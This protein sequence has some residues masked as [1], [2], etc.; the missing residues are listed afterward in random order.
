M[1]NTTVL[2]AN[3]AQ[4]TSGK[5]K[6]NFLGSSYSGVDLKVL[7]HIYVSN[8]KT[9][10]ILQQEVESYQKAAQYVQVVANSFK[11]VSTSRAVNQTITHF[12]EQLM[13]IPSASIREQ[14]RIDT[15]FIRTLPLGYSSLPQPEI[16]AARN[17][18]GRLE[19][20]AKQ[21]DRYAQ[22]KNLYKESAPSDGGLNV[23]LADLQTISVSSY[24]EKE[25]VRALGSSH[26]KGYTR[27][28]RT[29][30]G[31]MIFTIFEQHP[32]RRL[33]STMTSYGLIQEPL[34]NTELN[35]LLPDQL[36]PIDITAVF[37]NEYGSI[38]KFSLLGVEF[39]N[40]GATYSIE[41][42]LSENVVQ[43]VARDIE[44]LTS[45]GMVSLTSK[46]SAQEQISTMPA[47]RLL[48]NNQEYQAY[49]ERLGL[50][51]RLSNR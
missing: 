32:L 25:A 43:Y 28:Q 40:D 8:N 47:S 22:S 9:Q 29:V 46:R 41:D 49:L 7:A 21:Y 12:T 33:I 20:V 30:A 17:Y 2:P 14:V 34:Q 42:L 6:V 38:S 26:V 51:R 39:V 27:G 15:N 5:S 45:V 18:A 44:V 3:V 35:F 48:T 16:T 4:A 37:A 24:R 31:S 13:Q 1:A 11:V 50:K 36:P 10:D 23:E 19:E